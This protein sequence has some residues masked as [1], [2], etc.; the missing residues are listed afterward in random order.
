MLACILPSVSSLDE[1][2]NKGWSNYSYYNYS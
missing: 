1:V 2:N